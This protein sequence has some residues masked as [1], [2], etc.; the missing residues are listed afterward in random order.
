MVDC[1][2]ESVKMSEM[3]FSILTHSKH[4]KVIDLDVADG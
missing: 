4:L 2:S 3:S 1:G